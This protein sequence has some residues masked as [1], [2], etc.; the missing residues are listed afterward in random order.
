M[1]LDINS[2]A[3]GRVVTGYSYPQ[4]AL[5]SAAEGVVTYTGVRDLAR[6]VSITP[7]ITVANGNNILYLD[8]QAAERGKPKFRTG[9]LAQVVDGLLVASERLIMG[10]PQTAVEVVTVGQTNYDMNVYDRSQDIPYVGEGVVVQAQSNNIVIYYAFVYRKLQFDQFDVPAVTEGQEIDWQTQ[11]LNA[12]I[13][14]DDT[15][16]RAWKWFSNPVETELEAYNICR[17]ALG[18]TAVQALP[19]V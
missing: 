7:S 15:A 5:Y 12:Q 18:G 8:N 10:I 4:V 3:R 1:A 2:L 19:L 6:G 9:T 13:L 17:V 16:R 14:T 11:A